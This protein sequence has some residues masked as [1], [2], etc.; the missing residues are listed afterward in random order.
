MEY[1][2]EAF[3]LIDN[4]KMCVYT[5]GVRHVPSS[6]N[7][8]N[9][10]SK[11]PDIT[12]ST[13]NVLDGT[14]SDGYVSI[15]R[16]FKTQSDGTL[17]LRTAVNVSNTADGMRIYF[18]N[19]LGQ[20]VLEICTFDGFYHVMASENVNTGI[21]SCVGD[22]TVRVIINLDK[23]CGQVFL[24][25]EKACDYK[26]A[27][28]CD[29]DRIYYSTA[30]KSNVV[31]EPKYC[32]LYKNF[33]VNEN[34]FDEKVPDDWNG[35]G[36]QTFLMYG[37]K[38]DSGCLRFDSSG[39]LSKSFS[40]IS[41][42]FVFEGYIYMP[43]NDRAG[44]VLGNTSVVLDGNV[45]ASDTYKKS[46]RN[47]LFQCVHMAVDTVLH[48]AVLYV[49]GKKCAV[50]PFE[51]DSI[52]SISVFFDKRTD[53]GTAWFGDIKVYN[54]YDYPDYCPK[55]QKTE[56]ND[57]VT[58]MSVCSLWREG[59]H[60]GW[61]FVSPYD[62][63]SPL[64][65]YYDEGEPEEADWEIKQLA[66]HGMQAMQYCWFAPSV[67]DFFTPIKK[68]TYSEALNDGY[69]Y[70]KYS[71]EVKFCIMWE[72]ATFSGCRDGMAIEQFKSYLWDYWVEY[73]FTDSR[74]LVVDN[75]PVFE[76]FRADVFLKNFGGLEKC[77]EVIDFMRRDIKKYGFDDI[78]L[79]FLNSG[80]NKDSLKQL[81]DLGADGAIQYC[82]DQNSYYPEY[83]RNVNTQAINNVKA[84]SDSLFYIP[85]VST[86]LNILGWENKRSPMATCEQHE[87]AIDIYNEL[88]KLQGRT[89]M[90]LFSTWNEFGEGHWLAPS[91]LNGYGYAD[92]WRKKLTDA[93]NEHIDVL[94]TQNQKARICR[95]YNDR[96]TPIRAWLKH[97]IGTDSD[98][99][100][101][102]T[103]KSVDFSKVKSLTDFKDENIDG[104]IK[105]YGN[106]I[107]GNAVVQDP[108]VILPEKICFDAAEVDVIHVRMSSSLTDKVM[109]FFMNEGD[110][111]FSYHK[112][113]E[114]YFT[115]ND[116][117]VDFYF[118]TSECPYWKGKISRIRFDPAENLGEFTL[119]LIE[120]LK[121]SQEQK[122]FSI[123]ADG[124]ELTD[125]PVG[126]K[127]CG[128]G[129]FYVSAEPKTGFYSAMNFYH[130]WNRF[131]GVLYI[132]TGTDM[133]FK[134]TVGK[135][136]AQV[137]GNSVR[138]KRAFGT[139]DHVPTLPL[140]FILDNS[141]ID[142]KINGTDISVFIR[143][144]N[145][146]NDTE[147]M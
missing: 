26:L 22:V 94:P 92:V 98:S 45:L 73:Y 77:R 139:Y 80:L 86:G 53:N 21:R 96:R 112:R 110:S 37:G 20:N 51:K 102:I 7:Y 99:I 47:N 34:F 81:C 144:N 147:E 75:K 101:E 29:F 25:G 36:A 30:F 19:S 109:I 134:F 54:V 46:I 108:K 113:F 13:T 141:G 133:E 97:D 107:Y 146:K 48:Q 18:A 15:N 117:S 145:H 78:T 67:N 63:C 137:N 24:N 5:R 4:R 143:K 39:S 69:F 119:E 106:H 3:Y 105:L 120:F 138:L 84:V 114:K 32:I 27:E 65:G 23:S 116:K 38:Y 111:D 9:R 61:D 57:C 127:E 17:V 11:E 89:K 68:P 79:L 90:I 56:P 66:E 62:E 93:P 41:G 31:V 85:T 115:Y 59:M 83:L 87:K 12:G 125:I 95:L 55:P 121:Y 91:G 100:P 49:N 124:T 104:H 35:D 14:Q 103:V 70:A 123:F 82:W 72:N 88:L 2:N 76:I 28:F 16:N 64:I 129:E 6:W 126:Y 122:K 130:E 58:I 40:A 118:S 136:E 140:K 60:S 1:K 71:D 132:K 131:D 44:F 50:L 42:K 43:Y 10:F 128:D 74:Y 33:S 142:Y 8:E 52:D 135:S